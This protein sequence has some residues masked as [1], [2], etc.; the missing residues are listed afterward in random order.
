MNNEVK[1]HFAALVTG[2]VIFAH[3]GPAAA[4]DVPNLLPI[5]G[6]LTDAAGALIDGPVPVTFSLYDGL[7]GGVALYTEQQVITPEN[8]LFTTYLGKEGSGLDLALFAQNS[9]VFLGLSVANDAE[10]IPRFQ[11][12][13]VPF[14]AHALSAANASALDGSPASDF[15]R[16]SHQ[17]DFTTLTNLPADFADGVDDNTTYA[18]GPG[19]ALNAN[20]ELSVD[21]TAIEAYARNVCLDSEAEATALLDD[22]YAAASH[23]H[24]W[25]S[26]TGTPAGF[27]D[28]VDNDTTYAAGSGITIGANNLIQV[29]NVNSAHIQDG[30]IQGA[31]IWPNTSISVAGLSVTGGAALGGIVL[32][33][34]ISGDE[35]R[36]E[37]VMNNTLGPANGTSPITGTYN[38]NGGFGVLVVS[39]SGWSTTANCVLFLDVVVD[40]VVLGSLRV[41]VNQASIHQA[42]PTRVIALTPGS[43]YTTPGS[44]AVS[45][46]RVT[47]QGC[48]AN[49]RFD[50]F[51]F[52]TVQYL[53]LPFRS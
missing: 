36:A 40:N 17:H 3:S 22:N 34:G 28:G 21:A 49:S 35:W 52:F 9:E 47:S 5:Q 25:S 29:S 24:A 45:L 41:T 44:H 18:A 19:L 14:A 38:A 13:S 31:D 10:M 4:Q 1:L 32:E 2:A 26:L 7:V 43:A 51:D 50:N 30:A 6:V 20:N 12:G 23:T 46:N 39:G 37:T 33:E 42:L 11:L 16:A 48:G 27:A 8:G 53:E 15:S